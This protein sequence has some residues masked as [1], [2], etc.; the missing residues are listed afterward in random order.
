MKLLFISKLH[1]CDDFLNFFVISWEGCSP[2]PHNPCLPW[3]SVEIANRIIFVWWVS[4]LVHLVILVLIS[5]PELCMS[6]FII[7]VSRNW[8]WNWH[9]STLL[10]FLIAVLQVCK[11]SYEGVKVQLKDL[12]IFVVVVVVFFCLFVLHLPLW[13]WFLELVWLQVA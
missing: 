1:Q 7:S 3:L 9:W 5:C 13:F 11:I 4:I 2:L 6:Y 10:S 8:Y 12:H